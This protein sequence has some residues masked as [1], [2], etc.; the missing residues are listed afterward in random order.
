MV[1]TGVRWAESVSRKNNAGIVL[2]R[3]AS[4]KEKQFADEIGADYEETKKGGIILNNDNDASRQMTEMCYLQRKTTINP[5]I[6]WSNADVWE[7]LKHYGCESNPLYQCGWRRVGCIGCPMA[8]KTRYE[9]FERYP[10]F[11]QMYIRAFDR[12]LE[13]RKR[14]GLGTRANWK[15]GYDVFKMWMGED[16]NQVTWEDMQDDE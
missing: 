11:K 1:I 7:F 8:S 6:D 16:L 4:D 14:A 10:K 2:I 9:E 15:N 13:A 5:I 3:N 12:M